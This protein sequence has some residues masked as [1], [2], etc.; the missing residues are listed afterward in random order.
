M[1]TIELKTSGDEI[2]KLR[3]RRLISAAEIQMYPNAIQMATEDMVE[4][5]VIGI[6]NN[7]VFDTPCVMY[8]HLDKEIDN[9]GNWDGVMTIEYKCTEKPKELI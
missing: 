5:L 8:L 6:A 4:Q 7:I 1:N 9:E 3:I 2:K